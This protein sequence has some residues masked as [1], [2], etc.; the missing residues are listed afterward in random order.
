MI[1]VIDGPEKAGKSTIIELLTNQHDMKTLCGTELFAN[2]VVHKWGPIHPDDRV[3]CP[4]LANDVMSDSPAHFTVWDRCWSSEYVY[5]KLLKRD[6]R[7]ADDPWLGEWLY[8][9]A[10]Q[11]KF[12]VI[13]HPEI[14]TSRRDASDLPVRPEDEY[15]EYLLYAARYGWEI[16]HT[17]KD[18]PAASAAEILAK[19]VQ[20]DPRLP[21]APQYCG[22]LNAKVI[23]VGEARGNGRAMPGSWLPFTTKM[24]SMYGRF[25][26]NYAFQCGWTNTRDVPPQFL[27]KAECIVSCG[28]K[29]QRWVEY[30]VLQQSGDDPRHITVPHPSWL[31]RFHN[32]KTDRVRKE[33]EAKLTAIRKLF[34]EGG[35]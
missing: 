17:K 23:F 27:R 25:L 22:P 6:R 1:I 31:Y 16:I 4:V 24:S 19:A 29:A 10:V 11:N 13:T 2:S 3:Y 26:E 30:S 12:M 33:T 9:R 8:G 34:L 21:R 14:L 32:D 35:D 5:G 15:N 28:L 7:L 20:I 18:N